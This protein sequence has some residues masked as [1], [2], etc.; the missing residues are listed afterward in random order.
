MTGIDYMLQGFQVALTP[1]N[2]LINV[3]GV[4]IGTLVGVLPG[5]GPMGAMAIMLPISV[6]Y[7]PLAGLIM[8]AGVWY[9]AQYGGSTTSILVNIPGESSSVITCIDGYQMA[10]KGRAG[11]AL[12]VS[13]IGSFVA[14]TIGI[15][16]LQ[17]FA[18]PL[19][20][21]AL[22]IGPPEYLAVMLFAFVALTTLSGESPLKGALMIA[23]GAFLSTIGIDRIAGVQRFTM[24]IPDMMYGINFVPVAIGVFGIAEVIRI[25][26]DP[27]A[28]TPIKSVHFRELYPNREETRRSIMPILRGSL[29]GT[30]FGLLPGTP[31]VM[32]SFTSYSIEKNLSLRKEE[33]GKGAIEAVAGPESA[34]NSAVIL[35]L[36]PLL[37]LGIPFAPAAAL[38]LAGL[39]IHNVNPGPMLFL[40]HPN[41]FWGFVAA[42]Y[43]SNLLLLVLNLPL[44][45]LFARVATF[46]AQILMPIVG[47]FCLI[48]CYTL[49]MALFD[50]WIMI[51]AGLA[52]F[53]LNRLGFS[54]V[55]LVI[56]L[57]LG[58]ILEDN[59]RV[60]MQLMNG[61]VSSIWDRPIALAILAI[62]PLYVIFIRF[63]GKKVLTAGVA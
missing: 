15:I 49:R 59:L 54:M 36:I 11:A 55:P 27:Y 43:I 38:L 13:A 48:G 53:F 42:M 1:T 20:S 24:D 30:L 12:S 33:F 58:D 26:L 56:G 41:I 6:G 32:A 31:A 62:I 39:Q 63:T 46:R 3:I 7:G 57:V 5:L 19:A 25:T 17:L 60:T 51:A 28:P 22:S 14:G 18:P 37:C 16:A 4:V 47:I 23:F 35:A 34:N 29:I 21:A 52:G 9:G 61:D 2:L 44:V 45:G 8:L 40:D 10:R 50:V